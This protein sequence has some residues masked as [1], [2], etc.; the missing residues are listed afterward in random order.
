VILCNRS[1]ATACVQLFGQRKSRRL[2]RLG[3]RVRRLGCLGQSED[4]GPG[5]AEEHQPR[6]RDSGLAPFRHRCRLYFAEPRGFAG[7]AQGVDDLA[8]GMRGSHT[9]ILRHT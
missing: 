2:L 3:T 1:M 8:I 6:L 7:S 5:K 9:C 4:F